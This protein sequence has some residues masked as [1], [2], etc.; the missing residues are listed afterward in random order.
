VPIDLVELLIP[1][2]TAMLTMEMQRG[3][4]GDLSVVPELAVEVAERGVVPSTARLAAAA[5]LAGVRVVH[6]TA[7]FRSDRAGSA[8]NAP[9]LSALL[10]N[11]RHL[12]VGSQ[13]AEVVPELGPDASD[14]VSSRRHGI[15]PFTGTDLDAVLRNLGI[16]TV[17]ATGVSVNL[18]VLG[19]AIEAVNLGYRVAVVTDAVAGVPRDYAEAVMTN[20][21]ALLA[22]RVTVDDVIAAWGV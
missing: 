18:G 19:L 9:M 11:P 13:P 10:R 6:C 1:S 12:E 20:T 8:A 4:V 7:E 3:V 17:V 2:R 14:L 15:S 21:M 5:R 16:R 22:T